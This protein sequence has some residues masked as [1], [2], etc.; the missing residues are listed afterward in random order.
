MI[1]SNHVKYGSMALGR[2]VGIGE[3]RMQKPAAKRP[4][5]KPDWK[6]N[7]MLYLHDIVYMLVIIMLLL[8][9]FFRIIVVNGPSMK[10]TLL[11]GD[12]LLLMSNLF[13]RSPEY[14]DVVVIS[15]ESFDNGKP[16]VKRVIATEGQIVDIDFDNGIVYIDGLP[17]EEPYVSTPTVIREGME[18]PMQV[19]KGCV[20]VMGDNRSNSRDSR[21][22]LIGNVDKREVL[23]KV[24]FLVFPGTANGSHPREV[25]R[26]GAVK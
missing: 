4:E 20:F 15:K 22:P 8:T 5:E 19:Q 3:D 18:F 1:S 11:D 10:E 16:I 24:L 17:L 26:I 7:I 13:Y 21:F 14:G 23:G 12:Y 25:G 9:L 2:P 6:Q